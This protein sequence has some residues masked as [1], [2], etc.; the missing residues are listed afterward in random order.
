MAVQQGLLITFSGLD[1]AGKSTQI[2][3][4]MESPDEQRFQSEGERK[5]EGIW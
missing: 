3:L 5:S 2:E 1:G 4:R